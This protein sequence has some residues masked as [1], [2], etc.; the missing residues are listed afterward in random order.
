[1]EG[2]ARVP[3]EPLADLGVLVG[4]IVVE[5]H[6]DRL[7]GGDLRLDQIEKAD[8]F[9]V[10]MPM[11]LHVAADH[12]PVEYVERREQR[13]GA[14]ALVI[15]GHGAGSPLLERQAGLGSVEG[16]DLALLVERQDDRVGG[17]RDIKA[18]NVAQ[19]VDEL[20]IIGK[21]ELP[22]AVR[23]QAMGAPDPV[24]RT[25]AD[26]RFA[27][28]QRGRPMGRLTRR[29]LTRP[30]GNPNEHLRGQRRD[31]RRAGLVTQQTFNP[32]LHEPLLPAPHARLGRV[33]PAH[34]LAGA[35]PIGAQKNDLGTPD[36]LLRGVTI[37]ADPF[38]TFA[39]RGR[40]VDDDTTAHAR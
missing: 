31:A 36:V 14:V 18:D 38:E 32:F 5:D 20:G 35:D 17:W 40:E 22:N 23:L 2:E 10:P 33:R 29:F 21:L 30:G 9:L 12:G 11:P 19:L 34:D 25:G 13:G 16:L 26:P 39:V 6:V 7:T 27:G 15:M 37:L 4:G 3:L 28:H 1:M 8:E 24:N